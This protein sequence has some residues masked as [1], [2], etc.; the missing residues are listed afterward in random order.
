MRGTRAHKTP[1][2]KRTAG[3]ASAP[4][5]GAREKRPLLGMACRARLRSRNDRFS[6]RAQVGEGP[7]TGSFCCTLQSPHPSP[8]QTR[9]Q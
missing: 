5:E 1:G 3:G 4:G 9:T 8:L 2:G 6:C 7:L